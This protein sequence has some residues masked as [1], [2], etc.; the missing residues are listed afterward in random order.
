MLSSPN[1]DF[2]NPKDVNDYFKG[3]A[4]M[5]GVTPTRAREIFDEFK[6]GGKDVNVQSTEKLIYRDGQNNT[7][8]QSIM[9]MRDGTTRHGPLLPGPV[10]MPYSLSDSY[11]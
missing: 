10:L 1:F 4:Q 6:T 9:T 8:T 5:E 3:A 11:N 2:E 7:Y